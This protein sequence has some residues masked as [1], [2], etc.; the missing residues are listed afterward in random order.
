MRS[1]ISSLPHGSPA[2]PQFT[3][4][5][6]PKYW[7]VI[8]AQGRIRNKAE[9]LEEMFRPG[10]REISGLIDE[11][12]V[13]LY[14]DWAI[15]TGKTHVAGRYEGNEIKVTLRFMDVFR[16]TEGNWQVVASQATLLNE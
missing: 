12:Y 5:F 8:D 15:V 14:G 6:Y 13:R 1:R 16:R 4:A 3:N 9:V 11:V 2:I 10:E 7:S